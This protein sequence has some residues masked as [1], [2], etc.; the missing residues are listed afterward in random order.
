MRAEATKFSKS[1]GVGPAP[2]DTNLKSIADMSNGSIMPIRDNR[3]PF[4]AG[5][6]EL[7]TRIG[8]AATS[9]QSLPQ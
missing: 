2:S 5:L 8:R 7:E 1:S 3:H 9:D 4:S 6:A